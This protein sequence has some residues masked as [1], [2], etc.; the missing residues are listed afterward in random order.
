M[1]QTP[2]GLTDRLR[3]LVTGWNATES[4][5]REQ[6]N[7]G[8]A[9]GYYN[10]AKDLEAALETEDRARSDRVSP[11]EEAKGLKPIA[12]RWARPDGW[13]EQIWHPMS[14]KPDSST[15]P[16]FIECKYGETPA[17]A[18]DNR[19][20][21]VAGDPATACVEELLHTSPFYIMEDARKNWIAIVGKY[22]AAPPAGAVQ[23]TDEHW[24]AAAD[25]VIQCLI[26]QHT[27]KSRLPFNT[28]G[29]AIKTLAHDMALT[30]S[31]APG[32]DQQ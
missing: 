29:E 31:R 10:C 11:V 20:A 18:L 32:G 27:V 4:V 9:A 3:R 17:P 7:E 16:S 26:E 21:P 24:V 1:T 8:M 28:Y 25:E 23:I 2:D 15:S 12:W 13:R 14:E 5:V 22:L 30:P 6:G 19:S